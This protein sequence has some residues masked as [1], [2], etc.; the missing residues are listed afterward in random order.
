MLSVRMPLVHYADAT[1]AMR[2]LHILCECYIYYADATYTM[3]MLHILCGCYICYA[4]ATYIV[5]RVR[6]PSNTTSNTTYLILYSI[7]Y[8]NTTYLIDTLI[9]PSNTTY[10]ILYIYSIPVLLILLH[11][12]SVRILVIPA[13]SSQHTCDASTCMRPVRA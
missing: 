11:I 4:D 5:R 9:P 10:R 2:M 7:R 6:M 3:R 1:Y 8:S 12:S 13:A